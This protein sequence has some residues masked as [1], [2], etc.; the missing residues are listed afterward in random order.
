MKAYVGTDA[1]S[2]AHFARKPFDRDN[3]LPLGSLDLSGE[4]C[5]LRLREIDKRYGD[6]ALQSASLVRSSS[7]AKHEMLFPVRSSPLLKHV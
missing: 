2:A 3:K 7:L 1:Q 5:D 6:F 4:I